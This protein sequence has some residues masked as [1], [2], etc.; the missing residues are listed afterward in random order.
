MDPV[1]ATTYQKGWKNPIMPSQSSFPEELLLPAGPEL[2]LE[3]S[4]FSQS[5]SSPGDG[6]DRLDWN[7][8][9]SA[10]TRERMYSLRERVLRWMI[11]PTPRRTMRSTAK[12][13][14][15]STTQ[16]ARRASTEMRA[17]KRNNIMV[18]E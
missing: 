7:S 11:H 13:S 1:S 16:A 17:F 10:R 3:V 18:G 14:W 6:L 8:S 15:G 5:S 2:E 12:G 9:S 4:T